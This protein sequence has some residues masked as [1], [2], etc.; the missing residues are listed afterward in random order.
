MNRWLGW[1]GFLVLAAFG[2]WGVLARF[3]SGHE[4]ANY[5]SYVPW[6]LWVAAY[7]YFIGLSAGAF[8]LSA[9]VYVFGV[10]KLEPIGP[11]ALVVALASLVMALVTIWFDLGHM[12]RFYY[13]YLRPNFHSMMAWMVWLYTAYFLLLVGELYF[14]V[15]RFFPQRAAQPG[16]SGWVARVLGGGRTTP[17]GEAEL[18]RDER[19]LRLLGSIGVPLAIAFHGGVGALFGTVV[20]QDLWHSP[21]YPILFLTGALLSGGALMV[22]VVAFFWPRRDAEWRELVQFLGRI[23]LGLLVF[24]LILEWAEYSIPM[25]YGVGHE[26]EA[27]MSVLFGP[28]WYVYWVFHIFFGVV[29]PAY[30]LVARG[31]KPEM[32]GIAGGLVVVTFLAVRLNL[33]IPSL[34]DPKLEGLVHAYHD[35]RLLFEYLPSLFEWS[36][37]AFSVSLGIAI[38]Y[39]LS[40]LLPVMGPARGIEPGLKARE[41]A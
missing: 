8:L 12:E 19:V 5:G 35:H 37:V 24:D 23:V 34:V 41:V 16:F 10:K 31:T 11:L 15:R 25:W 6:G 29:V 40:R 9:L 22:A 3:T 36:V 38:V 4:L 20:A 21:I 14:A 39:V 28:F 1:L 18:R 30:L 32:V 13:V 2:T 7:I 17:F 33:V 27:L 26:Y